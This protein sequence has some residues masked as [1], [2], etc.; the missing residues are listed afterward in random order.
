MYAYIRKHQK[1]YG[2]SKEM[3]S[4]TE[5][6]LAGLCL[7]PLRY[8]RYISWIQ[9]MQWKT[10]IVRYAIDSSSR[11]LHRRRAEQAVL[12]EKSYGL[13]PDQLECF[14]TRTTNFDQHFF[15]S[16]NELQGDRSL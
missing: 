5:A 6:H 8:D 1:T 4:W 14:C 13:V 9:Y 11:S 12:V 16:A 15:I 3:A 7:A 10:L 2:H